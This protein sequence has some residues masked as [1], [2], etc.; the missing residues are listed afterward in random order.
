MLYY[1]LSICDDD[2]SNKKQLSCDV[3]IA[4]FIALLPR[5]E[6]ATY[7]IYIDDAMT[8]LAVNVQHKN[9]HAGDGNGRS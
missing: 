2:F 7:D 9:F 1:S 3:P 4:I 8:S 6:Y 5:I